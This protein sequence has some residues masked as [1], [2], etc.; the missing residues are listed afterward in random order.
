VEKQGPA[1]LTWL[2]FSL[3][4]I[5]IFA[6]VLTILLLVLPVPP[7][8]SA[9]V[10]ALI[11]FCISFIFLHRPRG[12]LAVQL[13][14]MRRGENGPPSDDDAEDATAGGPDGRG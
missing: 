14:R 3:L 12:E 5:G 1:G 13:D 7:W 10:A 6:V 9:I 8:V 4:R 11:A 2:W